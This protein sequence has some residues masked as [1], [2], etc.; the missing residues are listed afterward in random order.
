MFNKNPIEQL[1]KSTNKANK[2]AQYFKSMVSTMLEVTAG[3]LHDIDVQRMEL[4]K[5]EEEAQET[6]KLATK[7]AKLLN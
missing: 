7:L 6:R 3:A 1:R 2:F 4:S 5:I